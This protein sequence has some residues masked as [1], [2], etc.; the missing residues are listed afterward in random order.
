MA[1]WDQGEGSGVSH[2]VSFTR[3][4]GPHRSGVQGSQFLFHTTGGGLDTV[5]A[6]PTV[7]LEPTRFSLW[8][9]MWKTL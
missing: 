8:I 4:S 2:H 1:R 3:K 6:S 9:A 7:L 5:Q